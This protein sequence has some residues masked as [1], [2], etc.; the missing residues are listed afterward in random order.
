MTLRKANPS[1]GWHFPENDNRFRTVPCSPVPP[2]RGL[3]VV[4]PNAQ[5][6]A[7][8]LAVGRRAAGL[9][10]PVAMMGPLF[11]LSYH[12]HNAVLTVY[13]QFLYFC[14]FFSRRQPTASGPDPR[15]LPARFPNKV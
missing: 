15:I 14:F 2:A 8:W 5:L 9:A 10:N 6:K 7:L 13:S 11:R 12:P 3:R 4:V 1:K